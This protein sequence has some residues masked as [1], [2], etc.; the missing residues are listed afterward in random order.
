VIYLYAIVP[1]PPR[2]PADPPAGHEDAGLVCHETDVL[3]AV[4]SEH[5][6]SVPGGEDALWRHEQVVEALMESTTVL[7]MRFG[8]VL[9]DATAVLGVLDR[10][11]PTY[12][13]L[14][15]RVRGG[16]EV[17]VRAMPTDVPSLDAPA[18]SGQ[19][20]LARRLERTQ[21]AAAA[22]DAVHAVLAPFARESRVRHQSGGRMLMSAAYLV[23][24]AEVE[25]FTAEVARVDLAHPE[26]AL[27]STGPWPPYSF[28]ALPQEHEAN[29]PAA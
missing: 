12:L 8:T 17:G 23:E 20:Y 6:G 13:E 11:R 28:V 16:V 14:L 7:P 29:V 22:L 15:D 1:A 3:A 21:R 4:C 5:G 25:A 10:E 26:L 18:A 2:L 9:P 27:L 24:A 19:E